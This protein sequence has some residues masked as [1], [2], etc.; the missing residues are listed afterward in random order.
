MQHI[1]RS[2]SRSGCKRGVK[3]VEVLEQVAKAATFVLFEI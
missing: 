1:L 3:T 2:N